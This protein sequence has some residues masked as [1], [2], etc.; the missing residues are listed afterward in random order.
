[1]VFDPKDTKAEFFIRRYKGIAL[2]ENDEA[3]LR[4]LPRCLRGDALEW[5][6]MIERAPSGAAAQSIEAK[7][8][9]LESGFASV[10]H[11]F[12]RGGRQRACRQRN[13]SGPRRP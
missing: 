9:R 4:V 8:R 13:A 6:T 3:V 12:R 1:M 10:E 5:Y 7:R 11:Q 2:M